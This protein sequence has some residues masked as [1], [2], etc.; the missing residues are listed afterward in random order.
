MIK[1]GFD[2]KFATI[3]EDGFP[4]ILV[5]MKQITDNCEVESNGVF[6][7]INME[8][9]QDYISLNGVGFEQIWKEVGDKIK[10]VIDDRKNK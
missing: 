2:V 10:S 3:D 1:F 9:L 4:K 5:K 6:I 7:S 8:S